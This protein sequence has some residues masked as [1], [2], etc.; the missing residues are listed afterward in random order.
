MARVRGVL[1]GVLAGSLA[2][3]PGLAGSAKLGC[4]TDAMVV[5]DGSGS[6][7]EMG[8]N[9]LGA[10]RIF[11]AREAVRRSVP[12]IAP[13]R[14]LGLIV[15]GPGS[16]EACD[17]VHLHFPPRKQA[18]GEIIA[19]VDGLAPEGTTPLT[20]AVARAAEVL[21]YRSK[22]G[23]VVLVTDGK[24]TCGG[25]TCRLAADLAAEARDLTVHVIGFRV[26]PDYFEWESNEGAGQRETVAVAECLAEETG[27]MYVSAET[28]DDLTA[29]LQVTLGCAVIGRAGTPEAAAPA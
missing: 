1:A 25:E 5:F 11:D 7:A 3:V 2:L 19:A 6:M 24:E 4:T 18:A 20:E 9:A 29:A 27:G 26:R 28:V 23:V 12:H 16:R 14:R 8:F 22:A 15:Y 21:D 13:V 17:N 10:P